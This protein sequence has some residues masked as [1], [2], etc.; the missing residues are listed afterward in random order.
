MLARTNRAMTRPRESELAAAYD[1][2]RPRLVRAAY[3][4]LGSQADAQDVVS[5]CWLRLVDTDAR[6]RYLTSKRGRP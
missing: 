4:I 1:T 5:D 6:E 3:A 2:A